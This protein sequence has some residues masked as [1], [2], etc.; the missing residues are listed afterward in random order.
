VTDVGRRE[1]GRLVPLVLFALVTAVGMW[2]VT[3]GPVGAFVDDGHYTVLAQSLA[4]GHGYRYLNVPDQPHAT[5]F[6]P[7]YP[8]FLALLWRLRPSFPDNVALFRLANVLLT[9]AAS[10]GAYTLGR[11]RLGLG[12][13]ASAVA[14][15]AGALSVPSLLLAGM[16]LSEPLFLALL[17]PTLLLA[18]RAADADADAGGRRVRLLGLAAAVGALCGVLTLVRS[19]AVTLTAAAAAVL[20]VRRRPAAALVLA[21]AAVAVTVPWQL[22][23]SAHDAEVPAALGSMYSSYSG[24]LTESVR[25]H[26]AAFLG[27]V[28]ARNAAGVSKEVAQAFAP[29]TGGVLSTLAVLALAA[30]VVVGLWRAAA[31]PPAAESRTDST[32]LVWRG[33]APVTA[34]FV[35]FYLGLVAIWPFEPARFVWGLWIPLTLLAAAGVAAIVRWRPRARP[36]AVLRA[37]ALVASGALCLGTAAYHA[38]S[39]RQRRWGWAPL[40]AENTLAPLIQWAAARTAP[41]DVLITPGET[42]IFLYAR[43]ATLPAELFTANDYLHKRT[44]AEDGALLRR[45][46]ERFRVSYVLVANEPSARAVNALLAVDPSAL[47]VVGRLQSGA[48]I[49][50]PPPR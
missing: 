45:M 35:V 33:S 34:L 32:P 18:E 42:T 39:Y 28:L 29:G 46:L 12:H 22:W 48:V 41:G 17:F 16:L 14:A 50:A 25:T 24:W 13:V 49:L 40:N 20:L 37:A 11:K 38:S 19:I 30:I 36:A 3:P 5:H 23:V 15:A 10:V 7:G 8:A 44:P 43:R 27:A 4:T 31:G 2:A 47:R 26:G 6:P 21:L 1:Q 9:A